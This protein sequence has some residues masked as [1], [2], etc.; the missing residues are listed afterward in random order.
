MGRTL[1]G[2]TTTGTTQEDPA[3][4]T[5]VENPVARLESTG[6]EF[7]TLAKAIAAAEDG[8]TV[9]LLK[10][11]KVLEHIWITNKD[12]TIDTNGYSV[13]YSGNSLSKQAI[14]DINGTSEVTI[15]GNG[16]FTLDDAYLV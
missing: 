1:E 13:I 2:G 9:E 6:E 8:D 7:E 14:I 11:A 5:K 3:P 4:E 10:D 15:T 16:T 12:L